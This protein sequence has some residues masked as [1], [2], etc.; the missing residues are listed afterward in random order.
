MPNLIYEGPVKVYTADKDGNPY[1]IK[2]GPS[3]GKAFARLSFKGDEG[4]YVYLADFGN[5]AVNAGIGDGDLVKIAYSVRIDDFG[6]PE[7]YNGKK[8]YNL[9]AI[10]A[11]GEPKQNGSKSEPARSYDPGLGA[12]QTA[13]NCATQVE[14]ALLTL[15]HYTDKETP[16][17]PGIES[18]TREILDRAEEFH[19]YLVTGKTEPFDMVMEKTKT[20]LNATEEQTV[21][22]DDNPEGPS[23]GDIPF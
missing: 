6:E 5:E 8:Q 16:T 3:A 17:T 11:S 12:Y 21:I 19:G 18:V 10:K 7:L 4:D 14:C 2:N 22:G 1:T 15:G 9:E 23:N 20:D 13:L